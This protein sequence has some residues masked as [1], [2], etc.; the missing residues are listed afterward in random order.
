[1]QKQ[2]DHKPKMS[3]GSTCCSK[4]GHEIPV[5]EKQEVGNNEIENARSSGWSNPTQSSAQVR[6]S[7]P[8]TAR[9]YT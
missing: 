2:H 7:V 6:G 4:T 8:E 3:A 9:G 5:M 1:M